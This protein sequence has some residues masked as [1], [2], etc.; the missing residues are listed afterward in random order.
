M[1]RRVLRGSR[2]AN[3]H[4]SEGEMSKKPKRTRAEINETRDAILAAWVD[5]YPVEWIA[6]KHKCTENNVCRIARVYASPSEVEQRTERGVEMKRIEIHAANI[7]LAYNSGG[8]ID[9]IAKQFGLQPREV[10][11]AV[12]LAIQR[13]EIKAYQAAPSK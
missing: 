10:R 6:E 7:V 12:Y 2:A 11:G 13:G 5:C 8:G 1:Q 3:V 4:G 9:Q